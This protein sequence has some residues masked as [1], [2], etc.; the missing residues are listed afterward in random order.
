MAIE[1]VGATGRSSN[2]ARGDLPSGCADGDVL[3]ALVAVPFG[4]LVTPSGWTE[5]ATFSIG[6]GPA[7]VL[8]RFIANIGSEPES[9]QF[10]TTQQSVII[11]AWRGVDASNFFAA[12]GV[13]DAISGTNTATPSIT[14]T[15]SNAMMLAFIANVSSGPGGAVSG[16]TLAIA[17]NLPT[18]SVFYEQLGPAGP[19]G[20]RI[21]SG[22]TGGIYMTALRPASGDPPGPTARPWSRG[23]IVE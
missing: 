8:S 2:P 21:V 22:V 10:A 7:H 3:I 18:R 13:A 23:Y 16:M 5:E 1:F 9:Y 12:T 6:F 20:T 11:T 14:T 4:T 19:T 17:P 15:A